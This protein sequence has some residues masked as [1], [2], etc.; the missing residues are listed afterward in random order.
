MSRNTNI[1]LSFMAYSSLVF[2]V[3]VIILSLFDMSV[4]NIIIGG[5]K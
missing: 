1:I 3:S 5:I 4:I 2:M